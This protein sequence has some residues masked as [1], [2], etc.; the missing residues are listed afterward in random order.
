M[1]DCAS[2]AS[3]AK[4]CTVH[5][6]DY[7]LWHYQHHQVSYQTIQSHIPPERADK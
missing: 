6:A 3:V 5:T 7:L 4:V 1:I 2:L